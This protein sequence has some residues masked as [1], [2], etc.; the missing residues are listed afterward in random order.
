MIDSRARL[1]LIV[2]GLAA[3]VLMPKTAWL[4]ALGA[5]VLVV[6]H[7]RSSSVRL[8]WDALW[9]GK[10]ELAERYLKQVPRVEWLSPRSRAYYEWVAGELAVIRGDI[11]EGLRRLRRAAEG[12]IRTERDRGFV[13]ARVAAAALDA[14]D[15]TGYHQAV[16][17]AR[18]S[19]P[20]EFVTVLL[21]EL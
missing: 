16:A 11:E 7:F 18:R 2:V 17:A 15:I 12:R 1:A 3:A 20:T 19:K 9:A 14:G 10:F 21:R 5:L 6:T 8:A 4:A 13:W